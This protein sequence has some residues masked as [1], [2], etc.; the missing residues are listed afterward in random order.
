MKRTTTA[1]S[2]GAIQT[3]EESKERTLNAGLGISAG[4]SQ[5]TSLRTEI[6]VRDIT[7]HD[8][9][10]VWGWLIEDQD[11]NMDDFAPQTFVQFR[12][13]MDEKIS[14][15]DRYWIVEAGGAAIGIIGVGATNH[16][17]ATFRGICFTFP[18]HGTGIPL[19]AVRTVMDRLFERGFA[20]IKAQF[21]ADN[22]RVDRFLKKCGS[23]TEGY[24]KNETLRNSKPVDMKLVAFYR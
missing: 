14:Y 10:L 24:L 13:L 22:I 18:V 5:S 7:N 1:F 3:A 8:Y 9:L 2:A 17:T 15:G 20:K 23:V 19:Q 11:S 16:H 6:E 4:D 12:S 21:F